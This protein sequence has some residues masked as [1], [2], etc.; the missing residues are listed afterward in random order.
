MKHFQKWVLK[1]IRLFQFFCAL[2]DVMVLGYL[3]QEFSNFNKLK[4]IVM[5][6]LKL[7]NLREEDLPGSFFKE[8]HQIMMNTLS[9]SCILIFTFHVIIYFFFFKEKKSA[10][11]YIKV[12]A[13]LGTIGSP[14]L[15]I[16]HINQPTSLG[17]S[18][19]YFPY[20]FLYLG[21]FGTYFLRRKKRNN[22]LTSSAGLILVDGG[23]DPFGS[24]AQ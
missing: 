6:N 8:L 7:F 22:K 21:I 13:L 11:L 4:P 12:L 24:F 9:L 19:F 20:F 16:P 17:F 14:L 15:G 2:G 1:L 10:W 18:L 3:W 5:L 23:L